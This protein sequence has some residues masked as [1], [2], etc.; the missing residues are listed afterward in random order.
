MAAF[1]YVYPGRKYFVILNIGHPDLFRYRFFNMDAS[2]S[3]L[4]PNLSPTAFWDIDWQKLNSQSDSPFIINKVM[5]Y[6]TWADMLAVLRFYGLE[7]V[8][9]D[10]VQGAYYKRTALSFLCLILNLNESDFVAY[11]RRQS[12]PSAWSH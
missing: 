9:Q 1:P 4:L 5:N 12:R 10:A 7:R 6:G 2:D 11:Q 3:G 8:R